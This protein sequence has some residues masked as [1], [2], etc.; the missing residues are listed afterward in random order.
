M[1]VIDRYRFEENG[2]E[3]RLMPNYSFIRTLVWWL[4]LGVL[5]FVGICLYY[6]G[7]WGDHFIVTLIPWGVYMAYFLYDLIFRIPVTYIFDKSEKC[8]YRKL[9]ISKKIMNFDE[10]TYFIK[11]DNG[12]GY[13]AIGKRRYQFVKNYKIS[14]YFSDSKASRKREEEYIV[15]IFHPILRAVGIPVPQSEQ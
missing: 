6:A 1:N 15:H 14:N 3:I 11:D 2:S 4:A 8:I 12:G 13:Y 7:Q 10:M 5:A 9:Y